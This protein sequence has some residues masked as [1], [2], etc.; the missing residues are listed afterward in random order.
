MMGR[1]MVEAIRK[2]AD[3]AGRHSSDCMRQG[4]VLV[5]QIRSQLIK[6]VLVTQQMTLDYIFCVV[7]QDMF[8]Y[9]RKSECCGFIKREES[10]MLAQSKLP[11]A[12]IFKYDIS[13]IICQLFDQSAGC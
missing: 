6:V 10:E 4:S 12:L 8:S 2:G 9:R 7:E 5:I 1:K 11:C 13:V 3:W